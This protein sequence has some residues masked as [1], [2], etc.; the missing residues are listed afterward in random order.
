MR[1]LQIVA[2]EGIARITHHNSADS[3]FSYAV[4]LSFASPP[5]L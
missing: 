3:S 4:S 2:D 5:P 1:G